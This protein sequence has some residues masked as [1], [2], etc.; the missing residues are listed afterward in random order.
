[1][2]PVPLNS[3]RCLVPAVFSVETQYAAIDA[4]ALA[5]GLRTVRK[6]MAQ[7]GAAIA[8]MD[9]GSRDEK[10]EIRLGFNTGIVFSLI[11]G[12]PAGTAFILVF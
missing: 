1:M 3:V 10:F 7:M 9:L 8:T 2:S 12:R 11:E 4:K 6:D 5:G